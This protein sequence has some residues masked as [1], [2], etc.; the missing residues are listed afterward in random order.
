MTLKAF[1]ITMGLGSAIAWA[2]VALVVT[3][4]DPATASTAVFAAFYAALFLALA[5]T[6]SV[7]GFGARVALLRNDPLMSRH[8][9]V[10][11]RQAVLLAGFVVTC[12]GLTRA[13][14]LSW[15]TIALVVAA[16]SAAEYFFVAASS[17]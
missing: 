7:A 8:A 17:R 3:A 4:I 6:F 16:M 5:G 14:F 12:L 13:G 10:A 11:L 9:L 1:L 2:A 15:W